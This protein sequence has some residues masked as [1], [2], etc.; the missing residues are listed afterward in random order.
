MIGGP[1]NMQKEH[2]GGWVG[3]WMF[4]ITIQLD[5][6]CNQWMIEQMNHPL[7]KQFDHKLIGK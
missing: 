3:G 4:Y 2:V 6:N 7:N 1:K 5:Y